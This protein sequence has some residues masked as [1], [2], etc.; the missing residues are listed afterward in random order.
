MSRA[1]TWE[2]ALLLSRAGSFLQL[3]VFLTLAV[4]LTGPRPGWRLVGLLAATTPMVLF[5]GSMVNPNGLEIAANLAFVAALLRLRRDQA[6]FP[7]LGVDQPNRKRRRDDPGLAA[8]AGV[9]RRRIGRM[10]GFDGD[11]RASCA[12]FDP[13]WCGFRRGGCAS[14]RTRGVCRLG[15]GRWRPALDRGSLR[16]SP[17]CAAACASSVR[18]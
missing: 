8:R 7:R 17:P 9:P 13:C 4:I 2:T 12:V 18:R 16:R 5:I 10:G 11:G 15:R 14:R 1:Q 6:A 3:L